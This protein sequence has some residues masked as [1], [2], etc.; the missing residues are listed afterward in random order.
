MKHLIYSGWIKKK[1]T[2]MLVLV[3]FESFEYF[4]REKYSMNDVMT[5]DMTVKGKV[6]SSNFE[7]TMSFRS[8]ASQAIFFLIFLSII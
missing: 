3:D 6:Y 1:A 5:A 2:E 4:P 8:S 7:D